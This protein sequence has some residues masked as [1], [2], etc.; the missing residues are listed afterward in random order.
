[1]RDKKL[2]FSSLFSFKEERK[3]SFEKFM[4]YEIQNIF[5]HSLLCVTHLNRTIEHFQCIKSV[6]L[7]DLISSTQHE[8]HMKNLQNSNEA[9]FHVQQ[10]L[11]T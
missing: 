7:F 10:N 9:L 4:I 1:M 2:F 3:I 11:K 5:P 6:N 8:I